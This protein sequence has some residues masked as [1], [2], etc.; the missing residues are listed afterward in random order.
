[1][2][3]DKG[4]VL[5]HARGNKRPLQLPNFRPDSFRELQVLGLDKSTTIE[6]L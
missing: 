1:M 2:A 4:P 6:I 5:N 3:P